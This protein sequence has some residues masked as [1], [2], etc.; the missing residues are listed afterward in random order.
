MVPQSARLGPEHGALK[1]NRPL[2][3]ADSIAGRALVTVIAIMTFLASLAAGAAFLVSDASHGWSDTITREMTI[4]VRPAPGRDIEADVAKAAALARAT[5]GIAEVNVFSKEQSERL[6]EP[7]LGNGLALDELPIPRLIVLELVPDGHPDLQALRT[8]LASALPSA[9]LDDHRVWLDRLAAMA[10][11][12]VLI[13]TLIFVLVLVAMALAVAFATSG[14]MADN[15]E[16]VAVLH[17]VGARDRFIAR[18]FQRHFQKLGLK[19]G[20]IGGGSACLLFLV[21]SFASRWWIASPGGDQV[22]ALFGTF[23]LGPLGY[24]A[25]AAISAGTGLLTGTM[26]R[27]IVFRHLQNLG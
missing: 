22:E 23:A 8:A 27:S 24:V 4:Q 21:A 20:V 16:V 26:S 9:S 6:L 7:W 17:F 1:Q 15:R 5:A 14:A 2:V 11:T 19:G 25:I 12:L 13:A 3:P 10:Q 18:E